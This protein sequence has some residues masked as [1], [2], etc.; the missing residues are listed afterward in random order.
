[1][2]NNLSNRP[3]EKQPEEAQRRRGTRRSTGAD[4][5]AGTFTDRSVTP[6]KRE[7]ERKHLDYGKYKPG[8][9]TR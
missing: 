4:T 7:Q 3:I 1:M 5:P 9:S 8:E 2:E 6:A